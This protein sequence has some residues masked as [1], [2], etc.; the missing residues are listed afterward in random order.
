[1]EGTIK[2]ESLDVERVRELHRT[3]DKKNLSVGKFDRQVEYKGHDI[4]IYDVVSSEK[5]AGMMITDSATKTVLNTAMGGYDWDAM[6]VVD[7][8]GN[9]S[10]GYEEYSFQ[11]GSPQ[12]SR[13][14]FG[15]VDFESLPNKDR[16]Q[17]FFDY[18]KEVTDQFK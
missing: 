10:G 8:E 15:P 11:D 14:K 17:G 3:L 1:M 13:S 16:S 18:V 9:V 12:R 7:F 4:A 6:L 2:N 5:S